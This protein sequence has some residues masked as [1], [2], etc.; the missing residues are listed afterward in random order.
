MIELELPWPPSMNRYWR[1]VGAKT[2]LSRAGRK[3]R[4]AV[5]LR[6]VLAGRPRIDGRLAVEIEAFA[7][8]RRKLDLD[9]RLKAILDAL[10]HAGVYADDEQIDDLHIRRG[11]VRK[12][13]AL[14]VVI[15]RAA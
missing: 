6:V 11:E 3:Y 9:N 12:G 2:L 10:E 8:D 13:G 5:T 4:Q 14:A 1:H 7:P 15:R